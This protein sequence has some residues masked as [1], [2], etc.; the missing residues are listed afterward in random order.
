MDQWGGAINQI[1]HRVT[2]G[3]SGDQTY[4]KAKSSEKNDGVSTWELFP[5]VMLWGALERWS[6]A[7]KLSYRKE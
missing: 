4:I 6:A 1:L 2:G 5:D 3:D 7:N